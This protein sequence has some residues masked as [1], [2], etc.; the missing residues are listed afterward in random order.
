MHVISQIY[1]EFSCG[2]L[3]VGEV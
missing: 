1:A 3:T 2:A